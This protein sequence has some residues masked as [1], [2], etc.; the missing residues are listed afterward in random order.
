MGLKIQ[1]TTTMKRSEKICTG[2]LVGL[3]GSLFVVPSAFA[4]WAD[5][6][7]TTGGAAAVVPAG[8]A[9]VWWMSKSTIEFL[10]MEK[11]T[12]EAVHPTARLGEVLVNA[13]QRER[14]ASPAPQPQ[15]PP[16]RTYVRDDVLYADP[17]GR[18]IE[19]EVVSR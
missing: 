14:E 8:W 5:V 19:G 11:L 2:V 6:S 4:D 10:E 13:A 16:M 7:L 3:A 9:L 12:A 17:A 18:V 1:F 15:R